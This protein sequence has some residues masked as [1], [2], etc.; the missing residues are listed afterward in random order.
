M[1]EQAAMD[2]IVQAIV[3]VSSSKG[4]VK[5]ATQLNDEDDE[6]KMAARLA[7]KSFV[8]SRPRKSDRPQFQRRL[9][10][11]DAGSSPDGQDDEWEGEGPEIDWEGEAE[12]KTMP[13]RTLMRLGGRPR[14]KQL[15][16]Q[17]RQSTRRS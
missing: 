7:W 9:F 17:P 5:T 10:S 12:Q 3:N 13:G 8:I 1:E 11:A 14:P 15:N 16:H 6:G 4:L 2:D